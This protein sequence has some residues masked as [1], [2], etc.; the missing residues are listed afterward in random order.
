M[1][2]NQRLNAEMKEAKEEMETI[3]NTSPDAAMI[4]RL[5]DGM[6]VYVNN[7][8]SEISGFTREESIGKTSL[9]LKIWIS[10]EDR[11]ALVDKLVQE[12]RISNYETVFQKKDGSY[13]PGLVS[14]S[15][16]YLQNVPHM[17]SITRNITQRKMLEEKLRALSLTDELTGLQNRRGFF[18][19]AEQQIKI[20]ERM[21]KNMLLFFIDLNKMKQI[22]DTLG[23]QGGDRALKDLAKVLKEVFRESDVV[24]RIGGDEFAVLALD[25]SDESQDTLTKRLYKHLDALNSSKGRDYILSISVGVARYDPKNPSSLSELMALADSRMYEQ[26][27]TIDGEVLFEAHQKP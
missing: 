24:A 11:K 25:T 20:A 23:H 8:Y 13:F 10:R 14:A 9:D 18:T 19:L 6:I 16:I 17:F 12:R 7:A 3:F 27:R 4:S 26:K 1:M 21:K 22:N 5:S 2:I 15:I